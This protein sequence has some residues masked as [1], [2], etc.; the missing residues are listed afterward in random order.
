MKSMALLFRKLAI[1]SICPWI[2]VSFFTVLTNQEQSALLND[3]KHFGKIRQLFQ[4][5]PN[6]TVAVMDF[7]HSE[8]QGCSSTDLIEAFINQARLL[9][10]AIPHE[11]IILHLKNVPSS[12][13]SDILRKPNHL[14]A[15][16]ELDRLH[17]ILQP[18]AVHADMLTDHQ[19]HIQQIEVPTLKKATLA[20]LISSRF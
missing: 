6:Q 8:L 16:K 10:T 5:I 2:T 9:H 4:N 17:S 19:D 1:S 3:A 14:K 15:L 11:N 7:N 18:N 20:Q 12:L 13:L